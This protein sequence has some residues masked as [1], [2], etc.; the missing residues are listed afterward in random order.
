MSIYKTIIN[1]KNKGKK[2]F[3]L[4]IDP[5]KIEVPKLKLLLENSQ[6]ALVDYFFVGGSFLTNSDFSGC[7]RF[8]KDYSS[9][10]V[11]IF[12]G[13]N[14]QIS[15]DADAILFLSL[16]SGRNPEMLIGNHVIAAPYLKR[17]SLEIISTGYMLIDSGKSTTAS[18]M[19]NS[20]PIP[21]DKNDIALYTAIAGEMLG[22]KLIYLDA[23][24]GAI[25][26]V[27]ADMIKTV[28][29]DISIPLLAGGGIKTPQQAANSCK[30]GADIIVVGNAIE[31]DIKLIT[32]IANAIHK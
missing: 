21:H 25:N 9:I 19:S 2:Q 16:I 15:E 23:G 18:Y 22:M 8:I 14:L 17:S 28:S 7:I 20:S 6:K 31:K 29:K 12:P 1:N 11:V 4:L 10:P 24:S 26:P 30:A 27:S 13:T 3:A 32:S 5:D